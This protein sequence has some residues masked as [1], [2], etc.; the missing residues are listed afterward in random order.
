MSK[1]VVLVPGIGV[2][3]SGWSSLVRRLKDEPA[4]QGAKWFCW[5]HKSTVLSRTTP[6]SLAVDLRASI[7]QE[8]S[9][10]GPFDDILLAGHSMGGLLVRQ[11]YLLGCGADHSI[12]RRSDWADK[13]SRIILFSGLNRGIEP[14][15]SLSFRLAVRFARALPPFRT[16]WWH[17]IRGSDFVT[18]LRIQWIRYFATPHLRMPVVVQ[19]LGSKD[20]VVA[21]EDSVD[22]EQFPTA[23]YIDVPGATHAD[24][25][26]LDRASDPQG[27]YA[28]LR[29]AFVHTTPKLASNI[30]IAGPEQVVF[31][32]HGIRADN[33][34]W[35]QEIIAAIEKRWPAARVIGNQYPYCSAF[36]FAIPPLRRRYL[37]WFQDQYSEA[38]ARNPHATFNFIGHSN[39]TYLLGESLRAIPGMQFNRVVL[40]GSVL[41]IDYDWDKRCDFEQV[42]SVRVDGSCYDWPV[43]WLCSGLRGLGMRDVGTGG[44]EGFTRS[45]KLNK[46]E[47][48]WYNG[49]H[50]A[51]LAT[52]NLP[53]QNMHLREMSCRRARLA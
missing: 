47:F 27:R 43:G 23:F 26:N 51:P 24:L 39:G 9:A 1:L 50:S 14:T 32:L 42:K 6:A 15:R 52:D 35:V 12:K 40:V 19:L 5:D 22:I 18:N 20:D 17:L 49:G 3:F 8:W 46:N 10:Y 41:P 36:E 29:D 16:C 44:F 13:V 4:L 28:L 48:F 30:E 33:R 11:A 34:T 21:R 31:V 37:Q 7:D 45:A 38:L 2:G 25:I 53:W